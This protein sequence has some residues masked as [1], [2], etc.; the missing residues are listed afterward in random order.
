MRERDDGHP[1]PGGGRQ[2]MRI[3]PVECGYD[4]LSRN[5]PRAGHGIVHTE[6]STTERA[7][8]QSLGQTHVALIN[9]ELCPAI[10]SPAP[11]CK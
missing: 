2:K 10:Y 8:C 6:V 9:V 5:M 4:T 3:S 1:F 11:T 7:Y